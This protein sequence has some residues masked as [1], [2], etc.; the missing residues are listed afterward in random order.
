MAEGNGDQKKELVV[1][2]RTT[3][4]PYQAR[5]SRVFEKYGITPR[6]ILIDED[7]T[8]MQRVIEWTGFKS[9]PTIL[10]ANPGEDVPYE[11]PAPLARGASPRGIDRGTM[12]TEAT[13]DELTAWLQKHGV[14]E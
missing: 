13:E 10:M 2:T 9:V 6:E 1:Y 12:I 5:A 14:I 11:R 4:C 3:Y 8:A 7:A